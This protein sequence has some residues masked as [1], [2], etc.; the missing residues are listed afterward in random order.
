[1]EQ[2][3]QSPARL[4]LARALAALAAHHAS[5][6][7]DTDPEVVRLRRRALHLAH[8]C[9][10]D[11]LVAEVSA[12][13][14]VAGIQVGYAPTIETTLTSSELKIARLAAG[15]ALD[16]DIAQSLFV[17]PRSVQVTVASVCTKLGVSHWTRCATYLPMP[18]PACVLLVLPTP[19]GVSDGTSPA[20]AATCRF[21]KRIWGGLK[22]T[23][24]NPQA[25]LGSGADTRIT[26]LRTQ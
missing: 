9:G 15:G 20:P 25:D 24:R 17:T 10:A 7:G 3:E 4:E 18:D 21:I 8:A 6:R 1:M 22:S 5:V 23:S 19:S 12:K 2:L 14:L 11:A 13:L 16:R 26:D